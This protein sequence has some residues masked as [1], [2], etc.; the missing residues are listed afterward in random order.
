[1]HVTE[2]ER[3]MHVTGNEQ[4][5]STESGRGTVEDVARRAG[6]AGE[7]V[8]QQAARASEYMTENV[9]AYPLVAVFVA[10]LIGY[11]SGYLIHAQSGARKLAPQHRYPYRYAD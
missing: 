4:W 8:Y 3:S 6:A 7:Q 9:K 5:R 10:G 2:K 11:A 1:M